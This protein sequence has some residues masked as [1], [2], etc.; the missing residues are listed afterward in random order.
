MFISIPLTSCS[1]YGVF[2]VS[3]Q[4]P[5]TVQYVTKLWLTELMD[6]IE[7]V[8]GVSHK[9]NS[10]EMARNKTL[11]SLWFSLRVSVHV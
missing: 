11:H 3:G 2:F 6:N 4:D 5:C 1:L 7:S 10:S 9:A 8:E